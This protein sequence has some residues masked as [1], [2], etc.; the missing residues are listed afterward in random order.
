MSDRIDPQF[1]S[2]WVYRCA[3]CGEPFTRGDSVMFCSEECGDSF[4][5]DLRESA[6]G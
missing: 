2:V 1:I 6:D 5:A 4:D 3:Q